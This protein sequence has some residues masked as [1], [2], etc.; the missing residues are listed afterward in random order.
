MLDRINQTISL[1]AVYVGDSSFLF[2]LLVGLA[3]GALALGILYVCSI[4]LSVQ[5]RRV[6]TVVAESVTGIPG[7]RSANRVDSA[8]SPL[9]GLVLPKSEKEMGQVRTRLVSAGYRRDS[10]V[11]V[12][13]AWKLILAI[14]FGILTLLATTFFPKLTTINILVY[15]GIAV[16]FG[17]LLPSIVL[18]RKVAERKR[19]ILDAFPDT[20][21]MLVACS[22]A[23]LGLNAAL[24]RVTREITLTFPELAEELELVN[25]EMLAGADRVKALKGLSA[26]TDIPDITGLVSMLSQSIRFGTGIAETLR[27]YAMEF[28]DKRMQRAEEAAAKIGT[29]L[30]FPLVLCM[31]PSFFVVAVGPAILSIIEAFRQV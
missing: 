26:R 19:K 4:G 9:K 21:D 25:A 8:I 27:I 24:Q 2:T 28:R 6:R 10:A 13:Y 7:N 12:F 31:F 16:V 20:L 29:K 14:S 15:V 30:L 23:G 17:M 1:L 11:A 18:D 5:R 3:V 22:E